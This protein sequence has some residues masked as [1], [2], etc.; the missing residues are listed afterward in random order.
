ME[1][2][3]GI[4]RRHKNYDAV[5][6]NQDPYITSDFNN[7]AMNSY[8]E[9]KDYKIKAW[10]YVNFK[11]FI[12]G[13]PLLDDSNNHILQLDRD[14]LLEWTNFLR[15]IGYNLQ[16]IVTKPFDIDLR[17][18]THEI[19]RTLNNLTK[20][21]RV[22]EL[23]SKVFV[24][25][26]S[27]I[28]KPNYNINDNERILINR[29]SIILQVL[30]P[31]SL[32]SVMFLFLIDE[33]K[34]NPPSR[35]GRDENRNEIIIEDN[36]SIF[37][38]LRY[39]DQLEKEI[40]SVLQKPY[41]TTNPALNYE[42]KMSDLTDCFYNIDQVLN[43]KLKGILEWFRDKVDE[44]LKEM[45][46][47]NGTQFMDYKELMEQQSN[48][49]NRY[50]RMTNSQRVI[51]MLNKEIINIRKIL[52]H[53][54]DFLGYNKKQLAKEDM[55]PVFE[56]QGKKGVQEFY[57]RYGIWHT[58]RFD[59]IDYFLGIGRIMFNEHETIYKTDFYD[60][61][62]DRDERGTFK[63]NIKWSDHEFKYTLKIPTPRVPIVQDELDELGFRYRVSHGKDWSLVEIEQNIIGLEEIG[64]NIP[65]KFNQKVQ[66]QKM[67]KPVLVRM[68]EV[69]PS[70]D[71]DG[72]LVF[73]N[74]QVEDVIEKAG[75]FKTKSEIIHRNRKEYQ[76]IFETGKY[77]TN[78]EAYTIA[79]DIFTIGMMIE[80]KNRYLNRI[81]QAKYDNYN[82]KLNDAIKQ[83][84]QKQFK[85]LK[86][87]DILKQYDPLYGVQMDEIEWIYLYE[88]PIENRTEHDVWFTILQVL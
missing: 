58:V 81:D 41:Q 10:D 55:K 30:I 32:T 3:L 63:T 14:K 22:N 68:I 6:S 52:N 65:V 40:L 77:G 49:I 72:W 37:D 23:H 13:D 69:V 4:L 75:Q 66:K 42:E 8:K 1:Q 44:M 31:S 36:R 9:V 25:L 76:G 87:S 5:P 85:R 28:P 2:N 15:V 88:I 18:T 21:N 64:S 54:I 67:T 46:S 78:F 16:D 26:K 53:N 74:K 33:I 60:K 43:N 82:K 45:T 61:N 86:P 47:N 50:L 20:Y 39:T 79:P 51:D 35:Y 11:F 70:I 73:D 71:K 83:D 19:C 38:V 17:N 59:I 48:R 80:N 34:Y 29:L 7:Q 27:S 62:Y 56:Q 57:Y 84:K 12:Y 24:T